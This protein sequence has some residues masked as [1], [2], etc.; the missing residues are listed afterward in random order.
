MLWELQLDLGL[1]DVIVDGRN[2]GFCY[3]KRQDRDE[4]KQKRNQRGQSEC[5]RE[6]FEIETQRW[7]LV[8]ASECVCD[9][10]VL[11]SES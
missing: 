8:C 1:L 6:I 2:K 3:E 9:R 5:V 4:D 7:E 10:C 11:P